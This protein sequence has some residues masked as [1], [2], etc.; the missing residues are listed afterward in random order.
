VCDILQNL[1]DLDASCTSLN[2]LSLPKLFLCLRLEN[3][4]TD[5]IHDTIPFLC[6][7]TFKEIRLEISLFGTLISLVDR[8]LSR[9]SVTS[10]FIALETTTQL[11]LTLI[12]TIPSSLH[13]SVGGLQYLGNVASR[14]QR[15][16]I[17][18][19]NITGT[20]QFTLFKEF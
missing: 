18:K 1:V 10:L 14:V 7:C 9:S 15:V 5:R 6:M 11:C 3:T 13:L 19:I 8:A 4:G 20:T 17:Q 16:Y 12:R 2:S